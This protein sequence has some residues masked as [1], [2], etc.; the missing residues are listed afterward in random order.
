MSGY[1]ETDEV[2]GLLKANHGMS[3]TDE[4]DGLTRGDIPFKE[5]DIEDEMTYDGKSVENIGISDKLKE[6]LSSYSVTDSVK[7]IFKKIK[8]K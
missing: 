7:S 3:Y 2:L 6:K 5:D 1:D 8:R 4:T